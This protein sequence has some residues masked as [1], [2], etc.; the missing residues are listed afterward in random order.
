MIENMK[1]ELAQ[2]FMEEG[3]AVED[4]VKSLL[5]LVTPNVLKANGISEDASDGVKAY[6]A[7]TLLRPVKYEDVLKWWQ[8]KDLKTAE[9]YAQVLENFSF[10]NAT[11]TNKVEGVVI[12]YHT[13]REV[14]ET[15]MASHFSGSP[16]QLM[17]VFNQKIVD[18][19]VMQLVASKQPITI[20]LIKQLHKS[21]MHGVY[22]Q[23]RYDKGER[24]GHFKKNDYA[25]GISN[26]GSYPE[27]VEDDLMDLVEEINNVSSDKVLTVAAYLHANFE[28]I[29]PFADGNGRVGRVLLNYYLMLHDYPP[30]VIFDQDKE[31]YYMALE[32]FDRT[33]KLNGFEELL[34]AETIKTWRSHIR[35]G[36]NK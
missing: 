12:D 7:L 35:K 1:R 16:Q 6:T 2:Y 26:V 33:G 20:D 10:V 32:I 13:T 28:A 15:G 8:S 30:L 9:D 14:Y 21:L 19:R 3:L 18:N 17:A 31:A 23:Q 22:D 34:K 11:M 24:P 4:G 27:D 29:H 25:V 5:S 36:V